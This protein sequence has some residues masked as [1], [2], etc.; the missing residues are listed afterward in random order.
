MEL[1]KP[2]GAF[3]DIIET[4]PESCQTAV[5]GRAALEGDRV[6][7]YGE[8]ETVAVLELGVK[9][10]PQRELLTPDDGAVYLQ[11][12]HTFFRSPYFYATEVQFP[13]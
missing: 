4:D 8:P 6:V 3:V 11:H 5:T 10:Y 9:R 12:L 13:Q 7:V 2:T 1:P